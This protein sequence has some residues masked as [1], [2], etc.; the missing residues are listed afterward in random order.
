MEGV[1]K[2]KEI[3]YIYVEVYVF[4]ELK[5]GLLVLIDEEMLVIVVVF[6]NE[7]LEKFKLN[8]EEVCVWGGIMYVFVDKDIVF[9]SD[10]IMWVINVFYCDV[11]I[12]LI[13]YI[14]LLQLLFYYVVLIKGIDVDQLR[15]LVKFVI[16]E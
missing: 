10:D 13:I 9:V 4:G 5:Y 8:V 1:L 14:I 11:F 15:N 6:N 12:V 3:F 7:L 16:V 2:F